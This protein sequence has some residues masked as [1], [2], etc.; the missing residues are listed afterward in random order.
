VHKALETSVMRIRILQRPP[1]DS[2]DG[3]RLDRFEPGYQYE[4]GNSL[5]ALMLAEGWAEPVQLD[6]PALLVPFSDSDPF[7]AHRLYRG[8]TKPAQF[9]EIY[10]PAPQPL[11]RAAEVKRRGRRKRR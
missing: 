2:I 10:R 1:D 11:G 6:E 3:I 7:D 5:G 8:S 9:R 4:V